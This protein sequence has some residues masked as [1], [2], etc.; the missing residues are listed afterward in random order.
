VTDPAPITRL[1]MPRSALVAVVVLVVGT[2]PL[3]SANPWLVALFALPVL[4][5]VYVWRSGVDVDPG[6]VTV[7]AAF[8]ASRVPWPQ[9]A[10][11]QVRDRGQLWLVRRDGSA[12][13]LPTM[14]SRDLPRLH[15]ATGG[16]LGVPED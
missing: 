7:R 5:G 6:G 3:A 12:L 8:G 13:R 1:R 4:V 2:V 16:R 15:A 9:V 14:R 10:G 11:L